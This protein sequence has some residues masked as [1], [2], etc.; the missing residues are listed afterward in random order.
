MNNLQ[1][2]Y[3]PFGME[4]QTK[5]LSKFSKSSLGNFKIA[6]RKQQTFS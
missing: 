3:V 1:E 5:K 6:G 2:N 4:N